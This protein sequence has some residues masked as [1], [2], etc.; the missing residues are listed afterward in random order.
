MSENNKVISSSVVIY[1]NDDGELKNVVNSILNQSV[2]IKLFVVDNSPTDKLKCTFDN[3]VE[4]IYNDGKNLGYGAAHNL[5]IEKSIKENFIYHVVVNPDIF[6][7]DNVVEPLVQ[8]MNDNLDCG[9]VM[10]KVLYPNGETQYLCKLLPTPYDLI[11]RR[12]LPFKKLID[13][14]NEKYELRFTNY[15]D[16]MEAP[17]LSGCFMLMRIKTL[18]EI[19]GFDHRYFMYAE[20]MDLSRRIGEISRTV[21]FP[22]VTIFHRYEKGSYKKWKLLRYHLIS[23][24]K[25]FNK[26]GWF[27]DEKRKKMNAQC[28]KKL[29]YNQ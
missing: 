8:F 10:P 1:N 7:Y 24:I 14:R 3:R 21:F 26:W 5:A 19:G 22:H 13:K 17:S 23:V 6:F 29:K 28:L 27:F 16:L 11:G 2:N 15:N 20:D 12:F 4:Y 25:Y 9:L 18:K